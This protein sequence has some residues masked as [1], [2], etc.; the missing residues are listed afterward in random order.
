MHARRAL[1]GDVVWSVV[2]PAPTS[3]GRVLGAQRDRPACHRRDRPV[4]RRPVARAVR[5]GPDRHGG[6]DALEYLGIQETV[7]GGLVVHVGTADR[8]DAMRVRIGDRVVARGRDRRLGDRRRGPGAH[9]RSATRS[10]DDSGARV[11]AGSSLPPRPD[12]VA[13]AVAGPGLRNWRSA[14]RPTPVH[15]HWMCGSEDPDDPRSRRREAPRGR[16]SAWC[17]TVRHQVPDDRRQDDQLL[18]AGPDDR[19]DP[20]EEITSGA[21]TVAGGPPP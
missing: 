3:P 2:S 14:G 8:A 16:A 21:A 12:A 6:P 20:G 5:A 10:G 7:A 11:T 4:G 13:A 1:H 9:P 17:P 15:F 19:H 18:G